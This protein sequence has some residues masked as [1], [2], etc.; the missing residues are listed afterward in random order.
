MRCPLLDPLNRC[1]RCEIPHSLQVHIQILL[2]K[3]RLGPLPAKVLGQL[4]V[5]EE[6][7]QPAPLHR[8]GLLIPYN[9]DV[10][11]RLSQAETVTEPR[12]AVLRICCLGR[13]DPRCAGVGGHL[14]VNRLACPVGL[15]LVE[16]ALVECDSAAEVCVGPTARVLANVWSYSCLPPI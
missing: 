2:L 16:D 11:R 13:L 7:H 14:Q 6:E 3:R 15:G 5:L 10:C 12:H 8:R 1:P 9:N 4:F